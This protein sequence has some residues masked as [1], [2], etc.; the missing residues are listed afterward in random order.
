M[1]LP[2]TALVVLDF[3]GTLSIAGPGFAAP[4]TVAA[5]LRDCGLWE[6]G[7]DSPQLF[8]ERLVN[9]TWHR[10][11]TT[12]DGYAAVLA[13][14]AAGVLHERG[15]DVPPAT[16][17]RATA[18]FAGHY[19]A[20]CAIAAQWR[21]CLQ[22]LVSLDHV[23]TVVATDHYAEATAHITA[24]LATLGLGAVPVAHAGSAPVAGGGDVAAR[25]HPLL[26]A[27][28]AD[29]GHHK[30]SP[31]FWRAVDDALPGRGAP[32]G[33]R[34]VDGAPPG[35][36]TSDDVAEA[37][38]SPVAP[39]VLIDDFG[40]N[41]QDADHYADRE[42]VRRRRRATAAAISAVFG[43]DPHVV[44]FVLPPQA[45]D[46]DVADMVDAAERSTMTV[47]SGTP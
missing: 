24:E 15:R 17:E 13:G 11:S 19:F 30:S 7:I 12:P 46:D 47:L 43:V 1:T 38:A 20:H 32:P 6:L 5:R 25:G 40:E 41:E 36:R 10:G 16:I 18:A 37:R 45:G 44:P 14:A 2:A 29:I 42:R 9:P 39:V 8:W 27:N 21:G 4:D 22:R 23:A 35:A 33:A 28:S 3:S 26:I 34:T 31:E